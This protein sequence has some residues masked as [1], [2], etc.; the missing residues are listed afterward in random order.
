MANQNTYNL[1]Q[2]SAPVSSPCY[3]HS[4]SCVLVLDFRASSNTCAALHHAIQSCCVRSYSSHASPKIALESHHDGQAVAS[5]SILPS[6]SDLRM[7][8]SNFSR[9]SYF[10]P[11]SLPRVRRRHIS[12]DSVSARRMY[13]MSGIV[14]KSGAPHVKS[15]SSPIFRC[16]IEHFRT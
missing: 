8:K 16:P 3:I 5:V 1:L 7:S 11:L 4:L 13:S 6:R 14:T 10:L 9:S 15:R 12:C 2:N